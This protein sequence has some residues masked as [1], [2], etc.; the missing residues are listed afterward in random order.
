MLLAGD[1]GGTKS[2]LALF[3]AEGGPRAPMGQK[4]FRSGDYP[5]LD[6]IA[7]EY[8]AAVDRPVTHASFAVAGPVIAGRAALTNLPWV[9]DESALATELEFDSVNLLHD[10]EAMAIAVPYLRPNEVRTLQPGDPVPGGTIAV[11]APG[12]V[13]P[14]SPPNS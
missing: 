7:R 5:G 9:I 10:V 12:G 13:S 6:A 2:S 3:S 4:L 14:P 1:I 8:I 11:I